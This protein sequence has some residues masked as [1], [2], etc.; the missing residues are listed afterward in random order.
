MKD[1]EAD[2]KRLIAHHEYLS[3]IYAKEAAALRKRLAALRLKTRRG[4]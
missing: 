3:R 1:A 2:L 4:R